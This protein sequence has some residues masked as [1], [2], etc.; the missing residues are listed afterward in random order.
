LFVSGVVIESDPSVNVE[1]LTTN[2][3][4]SALFVE[5]CT[6]YDVA[7]AIVV[8][9]NLGANETFVAP[10]EGAVSAGAA[11]GNGKVVKL[12]GVENALEPPVFF[13]QTRQ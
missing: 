6:R 7:A 13:A 9:V 1:S 8:H 11:G 5:T 12:N 2:V 10:F 4:L 3:V